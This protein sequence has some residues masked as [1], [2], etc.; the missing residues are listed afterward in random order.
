MHIKVAQIT[1]GQ[2]LGYEVPE[3]L[4]DIDQFPIYGVAGIRIY[5]RHRSVPQIWCG[6]C[7]GLF[8]CSVIAF[9]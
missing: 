2:L 4:L 5:F 9:F 6:S 1:C 8:F 7:H 3:F